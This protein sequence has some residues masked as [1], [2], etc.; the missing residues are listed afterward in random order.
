MS[1]L[2]ALCSDEH[3]GQASTDL[4]F[5]VTSSGWD[6]LR[7]V[8]LSNSSTTSSFEASV[9]KPAKQPGGNVCISHGHQATRH[10][11]APAH[12]EISNIYPLMTAR[13]QAWKDT[14]QVLYLVSKFQ[15]TIV[16]QL[17]TTFTFLCGRC[18]NLP[19]LQQLAPQGLFLPAPGRP[20]L[21]P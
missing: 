21:H 5:Q 9:T 20:L 16:L 17:K 4:F 6:I 10:Q 11:Q 13:F 3:C 18:Q 7:K 19:R 8:A 14:H 2:L 12:N 1:G 15:S